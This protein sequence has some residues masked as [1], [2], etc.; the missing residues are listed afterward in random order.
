M[1]T[2]H[3]LSLRDLDASALRG[4]VA[5]A[6]ALKKKRRA[7]EGDGEPLRNKTVALLF[8]KPSTRT[9][10]SFEAAVAQFG[11]SAVFLSPDHTQLGRGEELGDTARVLSAMADAVVIRAHRHADLET[12]AEFCAAPVINALS[13]L[14]HPCQLLADVQTWMEAHGDIRGRRAAWVGDGN[15]VCNS[16]INAAERFEFFLNIAAPDGYR[17]RDEIMHNA[18]GRAALCRSPEE[19]VAG[20]D[21]VVT[22]SWV[23]MGDEAGKEQRLRDFAGHRVTPKLM[24]LAGKDAVFMHCLPAYRGVEVDAE[25]IDGAQSVVWAEAENRLHAQKALLE[26]LLQ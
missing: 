3:F 16:W 22:D 15:N 13:D 6:A 21:V 9:R 24:K 1:V 11:G 14:F 4:I 25:V 7:G 26:F 20:C 12:V 5:R 18:A 19:A 8:E 23:S 10:L 17:P 2:Q